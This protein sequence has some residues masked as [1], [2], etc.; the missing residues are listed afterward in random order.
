MSAPKMTARE[1]GMLVLL[2]FL[3]GGAFFFAAVSLKELTPH[4]LAFFRVAIAAAVL[5]VMVLLLRLPVPR[6][7]ASW[8]GMAVLALFSTAL[9]FSLLYWAQTHIASGL[10]AILNAMTPI[11]TLL[12][13]HAFTRDEKIDGER[14]AGVAAGIAGVAIIVGPSAFGQQDGHVLAE[15][16]VLGAGV[17]YAIASVFG[18]RFRGQS[19][20][21][22]T[23]AQMSIG[24]LYLLPVMLATGSPLRVPAP[25][26]ATNGAVIA[27]TDAP[28]HM[29]L[30]SLATVG[31]VIALG[32][33]STAL[34]FVIFFRLLARAGA[35]NA[36]LVTLLVPVSAI[37]L[38]VAVLGE[39]LA[40]R[41]FVGLA[42]IALGLLIND[43]RPLPYLLSRVSKSGLPGF[44][45]KLCENKG[46]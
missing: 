1:W 39:A 5:G 24:S 11:F 7:W 23:F 43:G 25:S 13:A 34:A 36:V 16:A 19:P 41:Q 15:I 9:P 45:K 44:G 37:L 14:L 18:R 40:L 26:L 2:S 22:L 33:V 3:W 42:L 31:A 21:T 28:L 29:A 30:P 20:V 46:L 38:G 8:R 6:D 32:T 17:S 4:G 12:V 35:N 27:A 10:A